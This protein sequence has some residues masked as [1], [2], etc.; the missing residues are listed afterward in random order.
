MRVTVT[1]SKSGVVCQ[2][3]LEDTEQI[4]WYASLL[5]DTKFFHTSLYGPVYFEELPQCVQSSFVNL[6]LKGEI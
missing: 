3:Y 2:W 4:F 1:M 6:K 5:S